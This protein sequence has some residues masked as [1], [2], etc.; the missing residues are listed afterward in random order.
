MSAK[1]N[2]LVH[3]STFPVIFNILSPRFKYTIFTASSEKRKKKIS[4]DAV[5][6]YGRP[7]FGCSN[8]LYTISDKLMDNSIVNDMA[9]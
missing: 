2:R 6:K 7:L 5:D 3:I 9:L 8:T 4:F 1:A